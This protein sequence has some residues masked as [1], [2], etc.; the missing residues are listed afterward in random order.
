MLLYRIFFLQEVPLNIF[1]HFPQN[2][3]QKAIDWQELN[4]KK[5]IEKEINVLLDWMCEGMD[6]MCVR[7]CK[8]ISQLETIKRWGAP[9]RF[10]W[11]N[12]IGYIEKDGAHQRQVS[13]S[14]ARGVTGRVIQEFLRCF[15][16]QARARTH[17]DDL[18][19]TFHRLWLIHL[20]FLMCG[21]P[22]G[23]LGTW[24]ESPE[25]RW[26]SPDVTWTFHEGS[27]GWY[28]IP[29]KMICHC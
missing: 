9:H 21:I 23:T 2:V 15:V 24:W 25:G 18:I 26:E 12:K 16:S 7:V 14:L 6:E 29:N 17:I 5:R 27:V 19:A 20:Q 4:E 1:Y 13:P 3:M 10:V 28:A 11:C 22:S 8:M